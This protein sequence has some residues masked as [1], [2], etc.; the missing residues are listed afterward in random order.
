MSAAVASLV[1]E[2]KGLPDTKISVKETFGLES[3]LEVPAFSKAGEHVPEIDRTYK[4]DHD[5]TLAVLAGFCA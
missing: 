2:E 1:T 5:T 4:F 3:D